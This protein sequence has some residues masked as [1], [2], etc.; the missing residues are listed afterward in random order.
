MAYASTVLKITGL[1][2]KYSD[3]ASVLKG[4]DI[5]VKEGEFVIVIGPSGAGKTT[6]IRCIN[7]MVEPTEGKIE[8]NGTDVVA[9]KG[10]GLRKVRAD[11]GM[12]FQH[13]NLIGR[14]NVIRNVMHGRL[15]H[16]SV[17]K[18]LFGG[19]S[20]EEKRNAFELLEKVGLSDYIYKKANTLSGGQM[21]RVGICRAMMQD[22]LL[23]LADEPIASLDPKSAKVVMDQ[24]HGIVSEKNIAC[25]MNLHQVH[26]AKDYATRIIGMKGGNVVYDGNPS[27]LTDELVRIIYEGENEDGR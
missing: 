18:S 11:I 6:F 20:T 14:T 22:P 23:L 26:I 8:F 9:L 17:F 19:Y 24:I 3:N 12:I 16:S 2:K 21:Q 15:G 5:E 13:Y 7:R 25:I 10:D 1:T 27:G 4:I